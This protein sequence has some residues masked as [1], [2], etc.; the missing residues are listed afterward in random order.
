MKTTTDIVNKHFKIGLLFIVAMLSFI[1]WVQIEIL[2][3]NNEI[4]IINKK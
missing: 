1:L 4:E 2:K 3:Q